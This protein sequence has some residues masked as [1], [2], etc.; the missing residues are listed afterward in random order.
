MEFFG[1][2]SRAELRGNAKKVYREHYETVRRLTP[3]ERLLE[4]DLGEV[5]WEPLCAFLGK[6]VPSVPFPRGNETAVMQEKLGIVF[7]G[8]GVR[9]LRRGLGIGVGVTAIAVV[10]WYLL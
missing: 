5:G 6:E 9:I 7:R 4:L 10:V 2:R 1:A 3:K 8:A